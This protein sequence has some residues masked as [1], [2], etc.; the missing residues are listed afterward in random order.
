MDE[1]RKIVYDT[2]GFHGK[3]AGNL[4]RQHAIRAKLQCQSFDWF[5]KHVHPDLWVPDIVPRAAG[6]ISDPKVGGRPNTKMAV[7]SLRLLAE[8]K[9]HRQHAARPR[10]LCWALRVWPSLV[11]ALR[12]DR[13]DGVWMTSGYHQIAHVA[14]TG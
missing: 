12:P 11:W 6:I 3:D 13:G 1:Y 10:R 2:R 7:H 5:L 14:A 8:A 4:T 9:V